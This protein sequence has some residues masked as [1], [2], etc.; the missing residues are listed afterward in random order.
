MLITITSFGYLHD[1]APAA[2]LTVDVRAFRDPHLNP[3]LRELTA[4]DPAVQAAVMGTPGVPE[5]L[6]AL[7]DALTPAGAAVAATG[8]P[9]APLR[10][11]VGCAGGRHRSAHV[12]AVLA[13]RAAALGH[14]VELRHR[15]I[16]KPVVQRPAAT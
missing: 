13:A 8:G 11:A 12:A 10:V 9:D 16:R 1:P 15:D 3:A 14:T 4:A 2:H 6:D 5:L 7:T